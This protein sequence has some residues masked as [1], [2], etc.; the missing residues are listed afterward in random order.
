MFVK[1][2]VASF[3]MALWHLFY[4]DRLDPEDRALGTL[5]NSTSCV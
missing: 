5:V 1:L 4:E 2:F 3:S